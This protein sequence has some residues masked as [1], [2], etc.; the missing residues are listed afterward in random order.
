MSVEGARQQLEQMVRRGRLSGVAAL[1]RAGEC[2]LERAAGLADRER[3]GTH[4]LT[5]AFP[6]G[7]VTKQLTA[8]AALRLV[9]SG[10]LALDSPIASHAPDLKLPYGARLTARHLLTHTS[11]LASFTGPIGPRAEVG[12]ERI[13]SP[14][15]RGEVVDRLRAVGL[16]RP[17]GARRRYSNTGFVLLAR[18]L[19][20]VWG[21]PFDE[22]LRRTVLEPAEMT[23]T[24][25][26]APDDARVP[27]GY[28]SD[29]VEVAPA[30]LLHPSWIVGA[31]HLVSTAA[32]LAAFSR[33][34]DGGV[35]L[36][37][38]SSRLAF[39]PWSDG[40][41]PGGAREHGYAV[42]VDHVGEHR[43]LHH[44]GTLPGH[45][46]VF[47]RVPAER[48]VLVLYV[49]TTPPGDH[50]VFTTT[51]L[52]GAA[53]ELAVRAL[54]DSDPGPPPGIGIRL[55]PGQGASSPPHPG[56]EGR[57]ALP[58]SAAGRYALAPGTMADL[59]L[60][61]GEALLT[62]SGAQPAL[63]GARLA[64]AGLADSAP[65]RRCARL[66]EALRG[67][68]FADAAGEVSPRLRAHLGAAGLAPVWRAVARQVGGLVSFELVRQGRRH[69]IALARFERASANVHLPL[70]EELRIDG[71]RLSAAG[72]AP[73]LYRL[74]P[75]PNGAVLDGFWSGMSDLAVR[76]AAETGALLL[77][78][79]GRLVAV[80]EKV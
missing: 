29:G 67:Q 27:V 56:V 1:S 66:L 31:G 65:G 11:G 61:D 43:V 69:L 5:E 33:A 42:M 77:E 6:I 16:E 35:L 41:A 62:V 17:P 8:V 20:A 24:R 63:L 74:W 46:C 10:R 53:V 59:H 48:L 51:T 4:R 36:A 58:P 52:V 50:R 26:Y 78:A 25:A 80:A 73:K 60:E 2:L 47:A 30:P 54:D 9:E 38:D 3:D 18:V 44:A 22:G 14:V 13:G 79:E 39:G 12:W 34:L 7:S 57:D 55:P 15:T 23:S 28:E 32:D 71:L 70:D 37:A 49:N 21:L 75:A 45:V 19:E 68:R 72:G 76:S 40:E 64:S